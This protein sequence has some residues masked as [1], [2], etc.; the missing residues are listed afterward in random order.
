MPIHD[1][2]RVSAGTF[3][4]FPN[5]WITFLQEALNTGL[6]PESYYALGEQCRRHGARCVG[7]WR[8]DRRRGV[9]RPRTKP[10]WS[11]SPTCR[12]KCISPRR[13]AATRRFISRKLEPSSFAMR[14]ATASS[15]SSKSSRG[16][17]STIAAQSTTSSTKVAAW[18][19]TRDS[20]PRGRPVAADETHDPQGFHALLWEEV[21]GEP[22]VDMPAYRPLTLSSYCASTPL[23]A[24]VEP[25]CVGLALKE[26]PLFLTKTHYVNVPLEATY[27]QAWA[28]V[29]RCWR[30]VIEAP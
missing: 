21:L 4:S 17:T 22:P 23:L 2:T 8:I 29:P 18:F 16:P 14:L 19:S 7:S 28:G 6:L 24:Y 26:M 27:Q 20:R 3:H 12:R 5:S 1:W 10:A 13:P 30:R 25:L 9:S 15:P 11:R